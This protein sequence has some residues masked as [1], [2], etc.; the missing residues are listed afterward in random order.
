[1]EVG[2]I[3]SRPPYCFVADRP[4]VF[5]ADRPIVFVADSSFIS[6]ISHRSTFSSKFSAMNTTLTYT[7]CIQQLAVRMRTALP[8]MIR[9]V[10]RDNTDHNDV[11][12]SHLCG[13]LFGVK[14]S[15]ANNKRKL[16]FGILYR[17]P[18]QVNMS[19]EGK[20]FGGRKMTNPSD[21]KGKIDT[22][23]ILPPAGRTSKV[24]TLSSFLNTCKYL[25][26]TKN[27]AY[28]N[29]DG[30]PL[31][32]LQVQMVPQD[33]TS[34]R[35]LGQVISQDVFNGKD[36]AAI[37]QFVNGGSLLPQPN[38]SIRQRC[39]NHDPLDFVVSL[40]TRTLPGRGSDAP[41]PQS[42]KSVGKKRRS[43]DEKS[44]TSD[45]SALCKRAR[46]QP[47]SPTERFLQPPQSQPLSPLSVPFPFLDQVP[48][49]N[50][51][52]VQSAHDA[53]FDALFQEPSQD[54]PQAEVPQAPVDPFD[55]LFAPLDSLPQDQSYYTQDQSY[56]TQDQQ[57]EYL[58]TQ[59][60]SY[61]TQDQSYYTQDQQTEYLNTQD[62]SYYTQDQQTEYLN[63]P[64]QYP[65]TDFNALL[66]ESQAPSSSYAPP[67]DPFDASFQDQSQQECLE[68]PLDRYMNDNLDMSSL[69]TPLLAE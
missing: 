23:V 15:N 53:A 6:Q 46:T 11:D 36:L 33:N 16:E 50:A 19:E 63:T 67:L 29:I 31:V 68:T 43:D 56:Y 47:S 25:C 60:Q 14:P 21:G 1:M 55:A 59:D 58:N 51:Q 13:I 61:Y 5:V 54:Q 45:S 48:T 42:A 37:Q 40:P 17:D 9:Y 49:P 65:Q 30:H 35:A 8:C 34:W 18:L 24:F 52:D 26:D 22:I 39:L 3:C 4:I 12:P 64:P 32:D 62:Q 2:P 7:T 41:R 69:Y 20:L 44:P 38:N 27:A 66:Q 28:R 10:P 57:T